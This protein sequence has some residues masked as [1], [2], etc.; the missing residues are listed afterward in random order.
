MKVIVVLLSFLVVSCY[1]TKKAEKQFGR[2]AATYPT[3]PAAYCAATYPTK[4]VFVK[5]D[6]IVISDTIQK[7]GTIVEDTLIT[8]DT[9]RITIT[10]ILPAQVI[11]KTI[12]VTDTIIQE[13]TAKLSLCEL[14]RGKALDLLSVA[15]KKADTFESKAKVRLWVIISF[16]LAFLISLYFNLRKLFK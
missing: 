9:V 4:T 15:N 3:I 6:T 13:N 5:G 14:E 2:A 16:L 1:S 7:D 8:F 10:K 12:H 11:T